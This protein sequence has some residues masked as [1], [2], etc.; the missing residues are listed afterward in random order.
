MARR[1]SFT[2]KRLTSRDSYQTPNYANLVPQKPLQV[3]AQPQPTFMNAFRQ[4]LEIDPLD[5]DQTI[6]ILEEVSQNAITAARV[7]LA[8][9][10]VQETAQV[11]LNA[12]TRTDEQIIEARQRARA[13]K[14]LVTCS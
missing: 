10:S 14:D 2:N 13:A 9:L 7:L 6:A 1:T 8:G 11:D 3:A 12:E 5:P 4:N